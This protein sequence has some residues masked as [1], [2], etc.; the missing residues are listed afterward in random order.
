MSKRHPPH[1]SHEPAQAHGPELLVYTGN[2]L[3]NP[4]TPE[5]RTMTPEEKASQLWDGVNGQWITLT[6]DIRAGYTLNADG[7]IWT[8]NA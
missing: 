8:R 7:T 3:I 6:D 2:G 1:P 4:N 5:Q